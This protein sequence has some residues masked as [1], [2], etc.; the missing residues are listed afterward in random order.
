MLRLLFRFVIVVIASFFVAWLAV[1]GLLFFT[2]RLAGIDWGFHG[3]DGI[4]LVLFWLISV[5][6]LMALS[7]PSRKK[8]TV[9]AKVETRCSSCGGEISLDDLVCSHCGFRFGS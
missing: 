9:T 4:L 8:S 1:A 5:I 3:M 2:I 6:F 7:S